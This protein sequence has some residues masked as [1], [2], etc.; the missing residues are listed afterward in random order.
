MVSDMQS[1][2]GSVSNLSRSLR[3]IHFFSERGCVIVLSER[4]LS[5]RFSN[6]KLHGCVGI[7]R[8]LLGILQGRSSAGLAA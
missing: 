4:F 2:Q 8:L 7:A 5:P 1:Q 6:S 3:S